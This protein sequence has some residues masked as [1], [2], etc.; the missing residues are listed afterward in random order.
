M[1]QRRSVAI[2]VSILVAG[3]AAAFAQPSE[4]KSAH[5]GIERSDVQ[6][7]IAMAR[8]APPEFA[9]DALL[10]LVENGLIP[11]R[12]RQRELLQEAFAIAA[13][14]QEKIAL[15]R[16]AGD[17]PVTSALHGAFRNGI[18]RVSLRARAVE[19]MLGLDAAAARDLFGK[20]DLAIQPSSGCAQQTVPDLALYYVAMFD[21]ARH[22]A[23]RAQ[24]EAFLLAQMPRFV[25]TAQI[26][27]FARVFL[28]VRG[29]ERM[30]AVLDAYAARLPELEPDV[31]V[32]SSDFGA[33]IEAVGQLLGDAANSN[34][35]PLIRQARAWVLAN[36]ERGVCAATPEYTVAFNG[37]DRTPIPYVDPIEK[38][39]QELGW[40]GH[41]ARIDPA[42]VAEADRGTALTI[43]FSSEY[44]E[45]FQTHLL[46]AR[47]GSNAL[48]L[49]DWRDQLESYITRVSDWKCASA[50]EPRFYLEKSDLL[51]QILF[52]D[53][54]A[55]PPP[56]APIRI[57]WAGNR[58]PEGPRLEIPGRDRVMAA[59]MNLFASDTGE[60]VYSER[61]LLWFSP[62]RDL[63]GLYDHSDRTF[64][65]AD[66]YASANHPVLS[67]YGHLAK[68]VAARER[69]F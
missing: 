68:L 12:R 6:A 34:R 56:N 61:R 38:F 62:V 26:T 27:P 15:K 67:L 43:P 47:D 58:R 54:H 17:S 14:A 63:L 66:L 5:I 8:S 22:M 48:A 16:G 2:G 46:L 10:T 44:F 29:I 19:A 40:R 35:E 7:V 39:N 3:A 11:D 55:P 23:D 41:N 60:K 4:T 69:A 13:D 32:F 33:A 9:A 31:R 65:M 53:R 59:L 25:S 45:N 57:N 36:V 52:I 20:I 49:P 64:A 51:E 18:D 1:R 28:Q 21:L 42:T 50:N 30:P 37:V 24:V